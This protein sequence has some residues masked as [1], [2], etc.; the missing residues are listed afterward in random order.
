MSIEPDGGPNGLGGLCG[1]AGGNGESNMGFDISQVEPSMLSI[2]E[3]SRSDKIR[4]AICAIKV[5]IQQARVE[6][7]E[8]QECMCV[9]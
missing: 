9:P 3:T 5:F 2:M 8:K 6:H 7:V 4:N 1:G